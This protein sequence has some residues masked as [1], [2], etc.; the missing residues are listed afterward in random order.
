MIYIIKNQILLFDI[1]FLAGIDLFLIAC[2]MV[3]LFSFLEIVLAVFKFGLIAD[4]L[5]AK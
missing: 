1:S 2:V 5:S 4:V 3:D